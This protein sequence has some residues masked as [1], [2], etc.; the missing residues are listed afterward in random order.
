MNVSSINASLISATDASSTNKVST[1][2][3]SSQDFLNLLTVQ[4]QNQD[5]MNPMQ[6]TEFLSQM[7]SFTSL[8]QMQDLNGNFQKFAQ[9]QQDIASQAYLGREVLINQASGESV[10]GIVQAVSKASDGGIT[11]T[12]GSQEYAVSQIERVSLPTESTPSL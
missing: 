8:E 2:E 5:P 10:S 3:L 6:D 7:A 11:V 1:N 9:S 12:V 4:L